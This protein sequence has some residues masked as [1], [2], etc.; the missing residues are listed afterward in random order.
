M[1]RNDVTNP[2]EKHVMKRRLRARHETLNRQLKN[3]GILS[4]VFHRHITKHD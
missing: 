3:W 4:W 2:V 1:P